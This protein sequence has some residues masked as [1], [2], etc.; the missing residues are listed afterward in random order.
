MTFA[1]RM[2]ILL[3][4]DSGLDAILR[5]PM[6]KETWGVGQCAP[7]HFSTHDVDRGQ[8]YAVRPAPIS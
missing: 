7:G 5:R 4:A 6:P 3:Q 1:P 2:F 8:F